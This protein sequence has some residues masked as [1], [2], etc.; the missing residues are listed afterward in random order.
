[1]SAL[2][3]YSDKMSVDMYIQFSKGVFFLSSTVAC[4]M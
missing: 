3:E 1:M 2:A 4:S